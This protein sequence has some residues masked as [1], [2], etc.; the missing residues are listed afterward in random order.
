VCPCS[1]ESQPYPRLHQKK[2]G[3]QVKGGDSAP[4]LCIGE[5]LPGVL[6]LDLESSVE[7]NVLEHIQR[8]TTKMIQR[9]EHLS[10]ED[11]LKETGLCSLKKRR[12]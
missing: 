11:R 9:M 3:Q 10:C 2:C 1:P 8:R 6:Q 5:T 7:T 12:F 4:L